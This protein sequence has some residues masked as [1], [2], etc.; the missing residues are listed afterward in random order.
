MVTARTQG[1][2]IVEALRL[3]ANDYV[4]KPIDFPVALA[5]IGTHLSHKWAVEDLRESEERYALAVRG[6]NDGLWDWNLTTNEVYWSPRWKAM[7]GYDEAEIGASPDEWLDA[8]ASTTTSTRVKRRAD[9]ASR[10]RR[11]GTTRASTGMLHRDGTLSLGALPRRGGQKRRR[12]GDAPGRIA[13]RHHRSQGGRCADRTAEPAAVRRSAR[14]RHQA[15]ASG[16]RTTCFALLVL[17]LDRFSVVNDSLG[18]LTADRLLVAV[19]R[20]LQSSLRATDAVTRDETG[21][22]WRGSAATSSRCCSTTSPTRATRSRVAERLRRALREAVRRRRAIRSSRRRPSASPSAPPATSGRRTSCAT[23]PSRSTARRPSG[24]T[25]CELFDPAMRERAVA[26]LQVET[27]LRQRDRAAARSRCTTSR[28]SRSTTGRIAGFE[29]LVRWRHPDAGPGQPARVHS[30]R[31]RHRDDPPIGRLDA[32]RIVP[33]DGGV[34]AA[35]RRRRAGRRSAS[36]SRAGSSRTP[37]SQPRS[38]RFCRR[39][40]WSRRA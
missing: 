11:A 22:R 23:P 4:T 33:A 15:D 24:T 26:R 31:G 25:A 30:D 6:A 21:S 2:D 35:V 37:T 1:A 7:L 5:R 38:R 40:G 20:R 28:S 10:R 12:R 8:R 39:P 13:D 17:G 34:A 19:A 36:T 14:A 3:G 32:R 27:D 16:G 29:A 18:P 9:G